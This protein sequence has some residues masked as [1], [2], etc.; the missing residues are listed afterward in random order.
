MLGVRLTPSH[1]QMWLS[2]AV[3]LNHSERTVHSPRE[4]YTKECPY[5]VDFCAVPPSSRLYTVFWICGMHSVYGTV[6]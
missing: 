1:V 5:T 3:T 2:V 4:L 6:I